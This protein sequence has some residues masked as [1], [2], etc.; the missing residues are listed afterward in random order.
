VGEGF[1]EDITVL[2]H[3]SK[4]LELELLIEAAAD[5]ADLFEVKDALAKQ[6]EHYARVDGGRLVLGYRRDSFVRETWISATA[7]EA[8]L[9]VDGIRFRLEIAPQGEWTTCLD[10]ATAVNAFGE[11]P[12]R[13]KYGHGET[14][15]RPNM[16]LTLEEWLAQAPE[17]DTDWRALERT[18]ER[19]MIDL[20]ALRFYPP[21]L[22][23]HALPAAGLPW[24]MTV[25]G[26]DSL[27]T[28]YQALPYAPELAEAT[29][30]V[31]AARQG[32]R[33]DHFRD[34]EP[35]KILHEVRFGEMT[36]FEERPHSPYYGTA[37][38]TPLF[39]VLLDEYVRWTGV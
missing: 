13:P 30:R 17:L 34:E 39:L 14:R 11:A 15:A 38:A 21:I 1:H 5:F 16:R 20:A 12:L 18:Y 28:S 22:P 27:M 3:T 26:R 6:G 23:G 31:L 9:A 33:V 37:D 32:I 2:N 25:F 10:V 8:D 19:S 7:E 24:F 36:A 29:L 4:P 35:G